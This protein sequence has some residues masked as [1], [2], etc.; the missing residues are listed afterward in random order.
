MMLNIAYPYGCMLW[1]TQRIGPRHEGEAN[2]MRLRSA[3]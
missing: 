1:Y 3:G 2:D